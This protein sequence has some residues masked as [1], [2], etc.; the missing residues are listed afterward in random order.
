MVHSGTER[1]SRRTTHTSLRTH[2]KQ[3]GET[4]TP[5]VIS[6]RS[7]HPA[8]LDWDR[9]R[10]LSYPDSRRH[11]LV[12]IVAYG[13]YRRTPRPQAGGQ[14]APLKPAFAAD[15]E[16]FRG[17]EDEGGALRDPDLSRGRRR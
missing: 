14:T 16:A 1:P 11:D 5:R 3:K 6:P 8:G 9:F 12:A 17:W 7:D 2:G 4:R 13:D 10:E 15:A